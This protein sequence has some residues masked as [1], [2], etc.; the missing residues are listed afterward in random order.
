MSSK[1][2]PEQEMEDSFARIRLEEEDD[3]GIIYEESNE[4]HV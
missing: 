3:E 1:K 2:S 4:G